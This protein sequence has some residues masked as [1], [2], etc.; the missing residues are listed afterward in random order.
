MAPYAPS[1]VLSLSLHAMVVSPKKKCQSWI[2]PRMSSAPAFSPERIGKIAKIVPNFLDFARPGDEDQ[3]GLEGDPAFPASYRGAKRPV[4]N[5][6]TISGERG[7]RVATIK[8]K[9]GAV[10]ECEEANTSPFKVWEF[11]DAGYQEV[12]ARAER[13]ARA[14]NEAQQRQYRG[15]AGES[16]ETAVSRQQAEERYRGIFAKQAN[17]SDHMKKEIGEIKKQMSHMHNIVLSVSDGL[18]RDIQALRMKKEPVFA[19]ALLS[20]MTAYRGVQQTSQKI[21]FSEEDNVSD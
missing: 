16:Q 19:G 3:L 4:G 14:Q 2:N 8:L 15:V 18:S 6:Q 10:T 13:D 5:I 11:S 17:D 21:A 9:S 7:E 12:L 20:E 1:C